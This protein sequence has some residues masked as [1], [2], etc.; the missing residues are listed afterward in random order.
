MSSYLPKKSLKNLFSWLFLAFMII[1]LSQFLAT[2][3]LVKFCAPELVGRFALANAI[4]IPIFAFTSLDLGSLQI[5]DAKNQYS[6]EDYLNVRLV[7]SGIALF[8]SIIIPIFAGYPW[9]TL[10]II[11]LTA[12]LRALESVSGIMYGL[13][14]K[15]EQ[16]KT[17][18]YLGSSKSIFS[19][20]L[21]GVVLYLTGSLSLALILLILSRIF[22][23]FFYE[24]PYSLATVD[25][26]Y[27][28]KGHGL[29]PLSIQ[30]SQIAWSKLFTTKWHHQKLLNLAKL[31]LP[32]GIVTL[33]VSFNANVPRYLLEKYTGEASLGIFASIASLMAIGD[34]VLN[35]LGTSATPRMS[36]YCAEGNFKAFWRILSKLVAIALVMGIII[37]TACLLIG[38]PFLEI[39]YRKEYGQY[40][41]LL[42]LLM[43][44][45]S[46]E[47]I[48]SFLGQAIIATRSFRL[49][50][51]VSATVTT[52]SALIGLWLIPKQGLYGA[53]IALL[54]GS[55]IDMGLNIAAIIYI[56]V[57]QRKNKLL[58]T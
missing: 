18:A 31:A 58:S 42:T 53:A 3:I 13:I 12:A 45:G 37:I 43:L 15:S 21:L 25:S 1:A 47:D 33:L 24:L 52:I 6:F 28:S 10:I 55:L 7:T 39:I 26:S 35:P 40:I 14:Q 36:Q 50:M 51:V 46:I 38:Q 16:M 29:S 32:M 2:I 4:T 20:L 5:T 22:Y 11:W 54:I 30:S 56:I 27:S 41:N 44:A 17:L 8:L 48:S 49:K 19:I 23:L 9:D 34:T 57:K